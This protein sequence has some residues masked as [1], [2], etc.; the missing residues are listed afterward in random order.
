MNTRGPDA[1]AVSDRA[2]TG[3]VDKGSP[4]GQRPCISASGNNRPPAVLQGAAARP[5]AIWQTLICPVPSPRGPMI[6]SL[7]LHEGKVAEAVDP[8]DWKAA[9]QKPGAVLWVDV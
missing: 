8:K 3:G 2:T 7:L 4:R 1:T 6:R 5:R 9:A